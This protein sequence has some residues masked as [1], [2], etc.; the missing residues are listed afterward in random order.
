MLRDHRKLRRAPALVLSDRVQHRYPQ[1]IA[2]AVE[3]MFRVDNPSPSRACAASSPRERKRLGIRRRDLA[4]DASPGGGRSGERASGRAAWSAIGFDDVMAT[5]RFDV[6]ER[7]HI[8]VDGD[9][10][11]DCSTRDCIVACPAKLF[12][13]TADGGILF[14]YEQ[15]FECGTCYLVCNREGAISWSY[16]EGGHGVVFRRS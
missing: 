2:G 5:T 6:H 3:A 11:R 13:P 10:C 16:P 8:V 7:A 4:R 14:N 9:V 12:V 15:C 1:L